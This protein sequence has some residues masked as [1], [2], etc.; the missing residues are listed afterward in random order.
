ELPNGKK[1]Q[2][3]YNSYADVARVELPTGGA[4]EYDH[5]GVLVSSGSTP[6]NGL[7]V[8]LF[9]KVTEKRIYPD[10]V[11]LERITTFTPTYSI[12]PGYSTP[13]VSYSGYSAS[14]SVDIDDLDAQ[15]RLLSRV[16]HYY[17]GVPFDSVFKS[18]LDYPGWKEGRE[19]KTEYFA[20]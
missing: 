16:R 17:I 5:A 3:K 6:R 18:S 19:T 14:T 1:Y 11:N 15:R 4:Y 10:G 2:F 7:W 9:R 20:T 12:P 13:Y 8:G